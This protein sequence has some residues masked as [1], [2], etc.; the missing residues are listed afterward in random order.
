M[1]ATECWFQQQKAVF[2]SFQL[3]P[4]I[5][6]PQ[7]KT[8][9]KTEFQ[10][11]ITNKTKKKSIIYYIATTHQ[12]NKNSRNNDNGSKHNKVVLK[13]KKNPF[14]CKCNKT[15]EIKPKL[16]TLSETKDGYYMKTKTTKWV[17]YAMKVS[18]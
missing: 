10:I 7:N 18:S 9:I 2:E 12:R 15:I 14:S 6:F 8:K 5:V 16:K 1:S 17:T 4:P 11:Q 3:F 13:P